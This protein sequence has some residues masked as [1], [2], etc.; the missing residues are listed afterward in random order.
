MSVDILLSKFV[1]ITLYLQRSI[2]I[3]FLLLLIL[4]PRMQSQGMLCFFTYFFFEQFLFYDIFV[5]FLFVFGFD[6][7][8]LS[9]AVLFVLGFIVMSYM[10]LLVD[11]FAHTIFATSRSF[12]FLADGDLL[13]DR[14][15]LKM[16]S[17]QGEHYNIFKDGFLIVADVFIDYHG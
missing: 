7:I 8:H 15:I 3:T 5:Y 17:F 13:T 11:D 14:Q 6:Y 9:I 2:F 4:G 10:L 12:C 16:F 1:C